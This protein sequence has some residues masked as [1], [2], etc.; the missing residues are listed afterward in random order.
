[1]YYFNRLKGMKRILISLTFLFI[2]LTSFGQIIKR[3]E[4]INIAKKDT[5]SRINKIKSIELVKDSTLNVLC[6]V[7]EEK[8]DLKIEYSKVKTSGM[9]FIYANKISIDANTGKIMVREKIKIGSIHN[10]PV[11]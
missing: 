6:W 3:K 4:A 8:I 10:N 2:V 11:F 9:K 5:I 7:I 1:M